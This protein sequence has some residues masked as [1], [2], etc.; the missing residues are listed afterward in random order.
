VDQ[1][2]ADAALVL[3][4]HG[5][6]QN[7]D[8][9]ATVI[10]HAAALRQRKLFAEVK[11]AFW[12]QEPR[13]KPA[14]DATAARR[15]FIVPLFVSE[16]YFS[17][18]VIPAALGFRAKD[19]GNDYPRCRSIAGRIF[20]Y[21]RPVGTHPSMTRVLMARA[22]QVVEKHPF[23]VLPAAQET[24]LFVAGHGT[25]RDENSRR[26]VER[27]VE[28]IAAQKTFA[29]VHAIFMEEEPKICRCYDL[30][31]TR[32]LVVVPFFMSDGMHAFEDIPCLLGESEARVRERL[33]RGAHPWRNPTERHGKMVWYSSSIGDEPHIPEV[34][35]ELVKEAAEECAQRT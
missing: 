35:L 23:P 20:H 2:F 32:N 28:L 11:E 25:L 9:C 31:L 15:V 33:A 27:Q 30:A 7:A 24:T 16:G 26:A 19:Q 10:Q 5:S 3:V 6:T 4:G 34:I 12:K 17:E 14:L 29:A 21:C 22:L 1:S 13:L 18:T 8:S